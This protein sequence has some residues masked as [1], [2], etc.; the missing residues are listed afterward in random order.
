MMELS[1]LIDA[2][3]AILACFVRDLERH[4]YSAVDRYEGR[5]P[6]L[7][8]A[9]G[10]LLRVRELL[11]AA[12]P[13]DVPSVLGGFHLLNRIARGGMGEVWEARQDAEPRHVA[14][15]VLRPGSSPAARE[16]FRREVEILRRLRD[17][18]VVRFVTHG[19][20][21][22][23]PYFAMRYVE[24][25]A[26]R[27]VIRAAWH[28]RLTHRRMPTPTLTELARWAVDRRRSSRPY[29][30]LCGAEDFA[31]APAET[32]RSCG[33][34]AVPRT[35][36]DG[37]ER[38]ELSA[39]YL[40]SAVD[41]MI[42][43]ADAVEY[44][45]G[46]GV[47][48]C[49]LKPSNIMVE[50]GEGSCCIIDFGLADWAPAGGARKDGPPVGGEKG[51]AASGVT[52]SVPYMAPEQFRGKADRRTD[53]WGLGVTLYELLTLR[54]PFWGQTGFVVKEKVCGVPPI[55]PRQLVR[56]FPDELAA[57][58]DRALR[59]DPN[60][61]QQ[62]AGEFAQE[63]RQWRNDRF[64][65]GLVRSTR[66]WLRNNVGRWVVGGVLLA[67]ALPCLAAL[68]AQAAAAGLGRLVRETA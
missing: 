21:H 56:D 25:A 43:A 46:V 33:P 1:S 19:E 41:F 64:R 39:G 11:D 13:A 9:M 61:R 37:T 62:T 63:L 32:D 42:A 10:E 30:G 60:R 34:H 57:V 38:I 14:V 22:G 3:E 35:P 20:D 48:H 36:G 68:A 23:I 53:V 17:K 65:P 67:T 26:L 2:D 40:R 55:R 50:S 16:Q 44:V 27:D 52:G 18:H 5:F 24:G 4:G 47:L 7:A 8:E 31:R 45:H 66:Q 15:K 29:D 51:D 12:R 59:K 54:R 58:C 6:H 49:D 28:W